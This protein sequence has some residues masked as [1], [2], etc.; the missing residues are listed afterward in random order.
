[1]VYLYLM[2]LKHHETP[3]LQSLQG[4]MKSAVHRCKRVIK[5]ISAVLLNDVFT[6]SK[7]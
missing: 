3:Q 4:A 7:N 5:M 1:M 2:S 6:G